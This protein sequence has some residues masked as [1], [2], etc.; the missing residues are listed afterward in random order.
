MNAY[1]DHSSWNQDIPEETFE[2]P[3]PKGTTV[4]DHLRNVRYVTGED[5]PGK[6]LD[7]LAVSV[8]RLRVTRAQ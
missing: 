5:D 1:L 3:L 7:A 4:I 6:N 2:L 8:H